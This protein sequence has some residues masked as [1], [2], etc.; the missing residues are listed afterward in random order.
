LSRKLA[1]IAYA[2]LKSEKAYVS[3]TA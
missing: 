1:R 3:K 2:L